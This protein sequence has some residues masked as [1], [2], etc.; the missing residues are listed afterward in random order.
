VILR[1]ESQAVKAG[2]VLTLLASHLDDDHLHGKLT[3]RPTIWVRRLSRSLL[4]W[5]YLWRGR[6]MPRDGPPR[7]REVTC[8]QQ[9]RDHEVGRFFGFVY[10]GVESTGCTC[11]T[12]GLGHPYGLVD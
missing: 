3:Q 9:R 7:Q 6:F 8:F 10:E 2:L 4:K 11:A 1:Q 12:V 5:M